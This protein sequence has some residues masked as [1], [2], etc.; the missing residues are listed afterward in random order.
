M[1]KEE[2]IVLMELRTS[3][4]ICSIQRSGTYFFFG[5]GEALKNTGV[6]VSP[7][8]YLICDQ[9]GHLAD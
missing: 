6:A 5:G 7:D 4:V 1:N 9:N 8:E 2:D 3:Y